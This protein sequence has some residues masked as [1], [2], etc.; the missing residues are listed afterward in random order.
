MLNV[1]GDREPVPFFSGLRCTLLEV[2]GVQ[3][4]R[5]RIVRKGLRWLS[6]AETKSQPMSLLTST[7]LSEMSLL[8]INEAS[9]SK[10]LVSAGAI[11]TSRMEAIAPIK[12]VVFF[13]FF[14]NLIFSYF[15][16]N[17]IE[18]VLLSRNNDYDGAR[19][20]HIRLFPKL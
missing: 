20:P 16:L 1:C 8:S 18:A 3:A 19:S 5:L 15:L 7:Y 6:E 10:A 17:C 4:E 11:A 13:R 12:Y 9:V 14:P 2:S